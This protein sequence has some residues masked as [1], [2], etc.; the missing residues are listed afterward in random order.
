MRSGNRLAKSSPGQTMATSAW[1]SPRDVSI[2]GGATEY[3]AVSVRKV[4]SWA[5]SSQAA[6]FGTAV[7]DS[8]RSS[9]GLTRAPSASS[10]ASSPW[11][12]LN[13]AASSHWQPSPISVARKAW[14]TSTASERRRV[15]TRPRCST[16]IPASGATVAQTS[17]VRRARAQLSPRSWPVTVMKPK[18]RIEAPLARGSRSMTTTR[19]PARAAAKAWARPTIPAPTTATSKPEC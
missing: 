13:A 3:T 12:S 6:S 2:R 19:L 16:A 14:A 9:C 18:L 7:R 10:A 15:T 11:R 1:T 5:A 4:T 8:T 17:R